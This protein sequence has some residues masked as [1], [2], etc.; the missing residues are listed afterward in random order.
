[1]AHARF[2]RFLA[3]RTISQW[4]DT[5]TA[6]ASAVLLAAFHGHLWT[7]YRA[8]FGL[9]A[10]GLFLDPAAAT[11]RPQPRRRRSRDRP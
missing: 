9:S 2:W 8:A 4:A 11:A 1:L 5:F 3:A 7:I 6:V 10:F